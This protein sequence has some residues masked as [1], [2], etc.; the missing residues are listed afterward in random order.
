MAA[1]G[2]SQGSLTELDLD[3]ALGVQ[4]LA[5]QI[6]GRHEQAAGHE[7]FMERVSRHPT[8]AAELLELSGLLQARSTLGA[9]PV[10]GLDD[11][12]LCLHAAYGARAGIKALASL[13]PKTAVLLDAAGGQREVPAASLRVSDRVL[14]LPQRDAEA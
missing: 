4:M 14:V 11:T 7:S 2:A 8:I 3:D 13:V 5:Y 1:V 12:P 6:D 10:P 9:H